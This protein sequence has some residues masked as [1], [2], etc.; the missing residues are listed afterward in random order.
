MYDFF[1]PLGKV[2][3]SRSLRGVKNSSSTGLRALK[4]MLQQLFQGSAAYSLTLIAIDV[5]VFGATGMEPID[6]MLPGEA[7]RQ[8]LL[9][10]LPGLS[11]FSV[12]AACTARI[13]LHCRPTL[14]DSMYL[15]IARQNPVQ[16]K[17]NI[18]TTH[19]TRTRIGGQRECH[20]I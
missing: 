17:T 14:L 7:L 16:R 9:R 6:G 3:V 15:N 2:P 13:R 18:F 10:F 1:L 20:L 4:F 12:S 5:I 11:G 8:R 19:W